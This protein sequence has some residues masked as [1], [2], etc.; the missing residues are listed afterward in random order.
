MFDRSLIPQCMTDE[1]YQ[2]LTGVARANKSM[3]EGD[4]TTTFEKRE[5]IRMKDDRMFIPRSDLAV[6]DENILPERHRSAFT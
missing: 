3:R 2:I 1:L 5:G 6:E 4:D